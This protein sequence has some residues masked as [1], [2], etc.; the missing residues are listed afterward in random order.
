VVLFDCSLCFYYASSVFAR[1][2]IAQAL[3]RSAQSI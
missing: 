2:D 1:Q 3:F